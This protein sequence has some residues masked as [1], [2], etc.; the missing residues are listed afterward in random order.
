MGFTVFVS[1]L[2]MFH[3]QSDVI[4]AWLCLMYALYMTYPYNGQT[5]FHTRCHKT[6]RK[7]SDAVYR[8]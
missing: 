2:Q 4:L 1:S 5:W 7:I 8:T 6:V 3:C